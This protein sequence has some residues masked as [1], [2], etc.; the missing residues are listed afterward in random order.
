MNTPFS[1][2]KTTLPHPPKLLDQVVAKIRF[3]H[4]GR[5]TEQSYAHGIKH[6]I[7]FHDKRHPK[8]M[9]TRAL[10]GGYLGGPAIE[11]ADVISRLPVYSRH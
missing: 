3:K 1:P 11:Y 2:E 7:H 6:F 4:Y 5:K 10:N 9:E 8:E